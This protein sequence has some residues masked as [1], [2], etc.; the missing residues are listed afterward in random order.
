M[1]TIAI[2]STSQIIPLIEKN[3]VVDLNE[4][5]GIGVGSKKLLV[6]KKSLVCAECGR[7]GTVF[8]LQENEKGRRILNLFSLTD[9]EVMMTVDHII[10]KSKGGKNDMNNLRTMCFPC[11]VRRGNKIDLADLNDDLA[12]KLF[13]SGAGMQFFGRK[14]MRKLGQLIGENYYGNNCYISA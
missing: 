4:Y 5:K 12:K 7:I 10:P 2:F 3:I 9:I 11:N 6:F 13:Y 1:K 14:G 8:Y